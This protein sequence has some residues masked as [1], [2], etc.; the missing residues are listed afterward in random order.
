MPFSLLFWFCNNATIA[1]WLGNWLPSLTPGPGLLDYSLHSA[2][3]RTCS[4]GK[5]RR[6]LGKRVQQSTL[7]AW[8]RRGAVSL[9]WDKF[10]IIIIIL[11]KFISSFQPTGF[12]HLRFKIILHGPIK[13]RIY[14][15]YTIHK[16]IRTQHINGGLRLK[17]L[18]RLINL[19]ELVLTYIILYAWL[20][21][22]RTQY[23]HLLL[24]IF[25]ARTSNST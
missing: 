14:I 21:T 3:L 13:L 5:G 23:W 9:S 18:T 6:H 10:I 12:S 19:V 22:I 16:F 17:G 8:T 7:I 15:F 2:N 25:L 1:D 11:D 24:S 20:Y 4:F